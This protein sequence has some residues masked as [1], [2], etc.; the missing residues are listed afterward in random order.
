MTPWADLSQHDRAMI[1]AAKRSDAVTVQGPSGPVVATLIGWSARTR[2]PVARV[3]YSTGSE[4]TVPGRD[5]ALIE[6]Y[7]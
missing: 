1:G 2:H 7:P 6:V 3:R 5:V 4:R